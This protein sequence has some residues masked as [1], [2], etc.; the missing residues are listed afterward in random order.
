[1]F[2]MMSANGGEVTVARTS[3]A[4]LAQESGFYA[5]ESELQKT[6]NAR[7]SQTMK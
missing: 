3:P 7:N 1:M 5:E 2:V 6:L 4:P